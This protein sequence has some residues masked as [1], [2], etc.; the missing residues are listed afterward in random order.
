M[1][2]GY[3]EF[4]FDLPEALLARLVNVFAAV[5][6]APLDAKAVVSIPEEQGIYQLFYENKLVYIGK[7]DAE[8]GLKKRLER[9][10]TKIKQRKNLIPTQATFKAVRVYVFTAVDLETQLI[11]HYGGVDAVSWNGSGFG[12]ND[13]G[14]ERDTTT[15]K[16]EH[17]DSRYPIDIE[18]K[19]D[20]SLPTAA[21]A[22]DMLR[23]L[24]RGL[25]YLIRF[26]TLQR[27][28]RQAHQDLETTTVMLNLTEITPKSAIS[29][30]INQ[31]PPG[32]HATMLPSHVIIYKDDRR[33]F[34]SGHLI[35]RSGGG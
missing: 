26:Q 22:A 23:S 10:A 21:T 35:G 13:P 17:F 34:P 30:I 20:F 7:T 15:Y 19:L 33:S 12:S 14:R 1:I 27:N 32:W 4:E 9:H 24:K 3:V 18:R 29:Q 5:P 16:E 28:S 25:P 2:P 11:K 8:L 6:A 31:L